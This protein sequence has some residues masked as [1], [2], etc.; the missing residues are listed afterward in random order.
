MITKENIKEVLEFNGSEIDL[1]EYKIGGWVIL[2]CD[3]NSYN[4]KSFDD[5]KCDEIWT[6]DF[7][8]FLVFIQ[9]RIELKEPPEFDFGKCLEDAGFIKRGELDCKYYKNIGICIFQNDGKWSIFD[10]KGERK[11]IQ[12]TPDTLQILI[13]A[14][15]K[16]GELGCI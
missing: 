7:D 8:E 14:A 6:T 1:G 5:I 2:L 13:T 9:K 15:N 3:D 4:F 10:S 16:L 11:Q 12:P